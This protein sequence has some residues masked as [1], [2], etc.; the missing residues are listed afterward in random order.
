MRL[1][2]LAILGAVAPAPAVQL[3]D[4][5]SR[6][7]AAE[8][9]YAL[10]AAGLR[11]G[12]AAAPRQACVD[13][14]AL[15]RKV[16]AEEGDTI[17]GCAEAV[18]RGACSNADTAAI[19]ARLCC[20]SCLVQSKATEKSQPPAPSLPKRRNQSS[21]TSTHVQAMKLQIDG[22]GPA[23]SQSRDV[24]IVGNHSGGH[25]CADDDEAVIR[26]AAEGGDKITGCAEAVGRGACSDPDTAAIMSKLC[27]SSCFPQSDTNGK[28]QPAAAT[29]QSTSARMESNHTG[30]Q[31]CVD[32]DEAIK[33]AAAEEGDK[34]AGCAEAVG[35]G[36]CSNPDYTAVMAKL[37]CSS[38]SSPH[39]PATKRIMDTRAEVHTTGKL[40]VPSATNRNED[41]RTSRSGGGDRICN[42]DSI[43][44]AKFATQHNATSITGCREMAGHCHDTFVSRIC[45]ATCSKVVCEDDHSAI[46]DLA[47]SYPASVVARQFRTVVMIRL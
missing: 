6:S 5:A 41:N 28:A 17:A 21:T 40:S 16:A 45:C 47:R 15:V 31:R 29:S 3:Q 39:T 13:D 9:R 7:F 24:P 11:R 38:C 26:V 8:E 10:L 4:V 22:E 1:R 44:V 42:D 14:D 46:T 30:G 37:C 32:D 25:T 36:A 27:C 18:G 34:I 35:R 33:R 2:A 43:A 19:M 12:A 20:S 23:D